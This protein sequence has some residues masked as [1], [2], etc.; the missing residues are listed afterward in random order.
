MRITAL[1]HYL[2]VP[3]YLSPLVL[4]VVFS[5]V[6]TIAEHAGLWGLPTLL[7]VGSWFFK[8]GF[9]VLDHTIEG[10][11][12]APILS[13][14]ML[15]PIEQRPMGTFLL[16]I[17]MYFLT[18]ELRAWLS[19]APVAALRI[20]LF[21]LI[22]AVVAGM[23]ITGKFFAALNPL[24][25]VNTIARI[26]L[27]YAF[28]L[29]LIGAVWLLPWIA[30]RSANE[31]L[32]VL[33]RLETFLPGQTL[34][35]IGAKGLSIEYFAHIVFMYC[36]L[37][38]FSCIG[39]TLY[40]HR[41]EL[42][43]E[44]AESPERKAARADAMLERER[45]KIMDRIFGELRGGALGNAGATIRKLIDASPRP[46]D[47]CRWLYQRATQI[48]QRLAN[49]LAQLTLPKLLE[50][51]ATGEAVTLIRDRLNAAP[52]FRPQTS[53]E[54]LRLAQLA[55]EA[56]DRATARKLLFEFDK[57]FANDPLQPM[58]DKLQQELQ[59]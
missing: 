34:V 41:N 46:L 7:I 55:R 58:V 33:W 43:F 6:L 9:A 59:R 10:R 13:A 56:G 37:A 20:A 53:G 50:A 51:K 28:L 49:F 27:A 14:E 42:E 47:E 40:E 3:L 38:M 30:I 1:L 8:Y 18:D 19:D 17:G 5:L 54:L 35:A 24:A 45:D 2:R 48:D 25:I 4:I 21:C 12:E 26:P 52:D 22:P 32:A 36:W 16:V 15:N 57:H 31:S 39:G 44:A 29:V 11:A 23:S